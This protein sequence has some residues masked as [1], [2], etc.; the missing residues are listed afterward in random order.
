MKH[1]NGRKYSHTKVDKPLP[2]CPVPKCSRILKR[3]IHGELRCA[4]T[5]GSGGELIIMHGSR[6]TIKHRTKAA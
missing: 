2:I 5:R 4:A 1:W 6:R 3:Y